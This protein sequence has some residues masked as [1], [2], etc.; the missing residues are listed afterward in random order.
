MTP[1]NAQ[2]ACHYSVWRDVC[3][4]APLNT[5]GQLLNGCALTVELQAQIAHELLS[6]SFHYS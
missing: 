4:K 2:K 1:V 5:N 6:D 3:S